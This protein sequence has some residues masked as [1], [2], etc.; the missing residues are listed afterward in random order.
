MCP[1]TCAPHIEED[2]GYG[3]I[4]EAMAD[5]PDFEVDG[6]QGLKGALDLVGHFI[7]AHRVVGGEALRGH[8]G[9]DDVDFVTDSQK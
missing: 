8:A 6:F 1:A 5:R 3:A 2:A 9:P 7:A 4:L